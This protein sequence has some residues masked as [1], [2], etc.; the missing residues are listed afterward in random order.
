MPAHVICTKHLPSQVMPC[1]SLHVPDWFA[2]TLFK[3]SPH[4]LADFD[5]ADSEADRRKRRQ[6]IADGAHA[7]MVH[8]R[9]GACP[10]A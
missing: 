10:C 2:C 1:E 4:M 7:S 8:A 6:R 5:D 9:G 3:V